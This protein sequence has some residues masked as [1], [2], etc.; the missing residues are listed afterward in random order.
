MN[1]RNHL[2]IDSL[3]QILIILFFAYLYSFKNDSAMVLKILLLLLCFWQLINGIISYKFFER[4]NKKTYVRTAGISIATIFGI[5]GFFWFAKD[6]LR[7]NRAL[8]TIVE[9][10][11]SV[12]EVLMIIFC[13]LFCIWYIILTA[14]EMYVVLFRTV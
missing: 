7:L 9:N 12:F 13:A 4:I 3:G 2:F 14:R 10:L 1:Y 6:L 5:N 11:K 8:L